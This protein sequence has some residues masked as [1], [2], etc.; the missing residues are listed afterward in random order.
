MLKATK[1]NIK[2]RNDFLTGTVSVSKYRSFEVKTVIEELKLLPL[3]ADF[4]LIKSPDIR[5]LLCDYKK[6]L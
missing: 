1:T 6:I 4:N 2:E 5:A 3:Q